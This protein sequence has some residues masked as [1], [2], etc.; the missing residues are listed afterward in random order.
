MCGLTPKH[1]V[2]NRGWKEGQRRTTNR[3]IGVPSS[4]SSNRP[5]RL[6]KAPVNAPRSCPNNS[7]AISEAGIAAQFT[8]TKAR[9]ALPEFLWIERAINSLPVPVSPLINTVES[10]GPTLVTRSKRPQ[11]LRTSESDLPARGAP[12]SLGRSKRQSRFMPKSLSH[13]TEIFQSLECAFWNI[14]SAQNLS[15]RGFALVWE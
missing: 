8:L 9:E 7:E 10:V 5:T 3:R 2:R 6:C 14:S 13:L 11:S 1:I 15:S 4:A 12:R